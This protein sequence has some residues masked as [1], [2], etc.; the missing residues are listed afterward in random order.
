MTADLDLPK[1]VCGIIADCPYSSPEA[2]IKKVC[3][4]RGMPGFIFPF[5]TIGAY[6]FGHFKIRGS[7]AVT[8]VKSTD[9][10]ILILHGAE[11]GFVPYQMAEEI[12]KA[13][14]GYREL[15]RCEGADHGMSYMTDPK[16][17]ES[18]VKSFITKCLNEN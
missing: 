10:P 9:V 5:V 12:Y 15:Y 18:R 6:L 13:A 3:R 8:S 2:I 17:Y 1:N 14:G 7:G 4:D 11:D 16:T